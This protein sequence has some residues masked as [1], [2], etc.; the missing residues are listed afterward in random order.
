MTFRTA[1]AQALTD[2]SEIP[3]AINKLSASSPE[4]ILAHAGKPVGAREPKRS[5]QPCAP[6]IPAHAGKPV[7][8]DLR[9]RL[10]PD[11][12]IAAGAAPG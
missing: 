7:G 5:T 3:I 6:S 1:V 10:R 12:E 9:V 4:S 8:A 2:H 11:A